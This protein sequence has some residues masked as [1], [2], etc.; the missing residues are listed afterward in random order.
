MVPL[1]SLIVAFAAAVRG[2]STNRMRAGLTALGI[3]IGVG[4]V[5]IAVAI[6]QGSRAAV[7]ASIQRL[8]TNVLTV[9]PGQQR[10][11][12][13]SFG[14]GSSSTLKPEDAEAISTQASSIVN[15]SPQVRQSA[16]VKFGDKNTTTTVTGVGVAYPTISNHPVGKGLFFSEVDVRSLRRVAVLGATTATDLFDQRTAVG[17]TIRIAGQGFRVVGVLQKKGGQGPFNPDDGVYIPVTTAMHRLLGT[18]S[19]Q[20]ILCQ[21]TSFSSM[22]RAQSEITRLL[23]KKHNIRDGADAD[24]IIFNQADLAAAQNEQQDTFSSLITWLAV[25]SLAVGGIG[26][27]NIMLVS[28]TER[29][30][31]IGLRM[32]VGARRQDVLNQFVLES[33][34]LSVIGGLFGILLG[35]IGSRVVAATNGWTIVVSL[36]T[37][38]LACGVSAVVGV[39]FGLYPALKA[40]RLRPVEALRYE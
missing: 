18:E 3:V 32:A 2:L 13:I 26:I 24:F 15:V 6:G 34:A 16:Q 7:Q 33:L 39:G 30:R 4:A 40:S 35:V 31:E 38:L 14:F 28:V 23:R 37:V 9:F 17:S 12:Q 27:M 10:R 21:A 20:T 11:G 22:K 5:I 8:G 25:V 36:P 29:T 1:Q 19:L